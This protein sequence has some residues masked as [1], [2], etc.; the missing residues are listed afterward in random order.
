MTKKNW[1]ATLTTGTGFAADGSYIPPE[2]IPVC[3]TNAQSAFKTVEHI[4]GWTCFEIDRAWLSD[5]ME[6]TEEEGL[7]YEFVLLD[8]SQED[9]EKT[10]YRLQAILKGWFKQK[11]IVVEL[12]PTSSTIF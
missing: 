4:T 2:I 12:E 11:S 7:R 3:R 1:K 9:A 10:L 8:L 6:W 5:E